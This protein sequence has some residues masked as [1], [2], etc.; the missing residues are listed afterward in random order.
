MNGLSVKLIHLLPILLT[1]GLSHEGPYLAAAAVGTDICPRARSEREG[2][3]ERESQEEVGAAEHLSVDEGRDTSSQ[4][5]CWMSNSITCSSSQQRISGASGGGQDSYPTE[6]QTSGLNSAH[7]GALRTN[8]PTQSHISIAQSAAPCQEYTSIRMH[9]LIIIFHVFACVELLYKCR[10]YYIWG[11]RL[12]TR[13]SSRVL[14]R[15]CRLWRAQHR[16]CVCEVLVCTNTSSILTEAPLFRLRL[17]CPELTPTTPP[18][19][20]NVFPLLS[21]SCFP[22]SVFCPILVLSHCFLTITW[23]V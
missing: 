1:F 22:S 15:D 2:D 20:Q 9:T 7:S 5:G 11:N 4:K 3:R 17:D 23:K 14:Q 10:M 16:F 13:Y 21:H 19:Y 8:P 6:G 12:H 18:C